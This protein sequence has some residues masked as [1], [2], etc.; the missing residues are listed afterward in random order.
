[1]A[2]RAA[3]RN[4]PTGARAKLLRV[5]CFALAVAP[6]LTCCLWLSWPRP[7][8]CPDRNLIR[9]GMEPDEVRAT[10]GEPKSVDARPD[11]DSWFYD[12][13]W[14]NPSPPISVSFD[15][16]RRVRYVYILD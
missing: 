10:L 12:C 16:D 8:S 7:Q 1:M 4:T 3:D 15:K 2:E 13:P 5:G 9:I 6:F 14:W 11:G